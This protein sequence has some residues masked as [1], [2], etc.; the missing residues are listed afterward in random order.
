M[1]KRSPIKTVFANVKIKS[2]SGISI[3]DRAEPITSKTVRKYRPSVDYTRPATQLLQSLGFKVLHVGPMMINI[4]GPQALFE[5]VFKKRLTLKTEESK[6]KKLT[7]VVWE[8]EDSKVRGLIPASKT[9]LAPY[10]EGISLCQPVQWFQN[11]TP[12]RTPPAVNYYHLEVPSDVA[13]LMDADQVHNEGVKGAGIRVAIVDTGWYRHPYYDAQGYPIPWICLGPGAEDVATDDEGHGTGIT[14][15]L[16]AIAPESDVLIV[17]MN[18]YN[19]LASFS[20]AAD[21]L[22]D[23]ISCSWGWDCETVSDLDSDML[24]MEAA[25]SD[26]VANG[27]VVLFA[28]GNGQYC[29]PA[30]HPDV[31]AVGGVY[32]DQQGAMQASSYASGFESKIYWRRKVPDV[33]GLVGNDPGFP[34]LPPS[35]PGWPGGMYIMMP[36]QPG[37]EEDI[38]FSNNGATHPLDPATTHPPYGDETQPDDGWLVA[39]GTSSATPQVA[40]ICALMRQVR[41]EMGPLTIWRILKNTARDVRAGHANALTGGNAAG[42][43]EDLATGA[44]LADCKASV[45]GA[46]IWIYPP[47]KKVDVRVLD[48]RFL[49]GRI[50][51]LVRSMGGSPPVPWPVDPVGF[52]SMRALVSRFPLGRHYPVRRRADRRAAHP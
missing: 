5:H 51:E 14:S 52:P 39:S 25:V 15:N 3:F 48:P 28:A 8:V 17:K 9:P 44:G 18:R 20:A 40:G 30:Q 4:A 23:V 38:R 1:S 46:R 34:G 47:Y 49:D 31:I 27:I 32:V 2:A 24:L 13:R 41:P 26:A 50:M 33:C 12:S 43:G 45:Q 10:S 7:K 29:F 42:P 21:Q 16:L 6:D 35:I 22:P 36:T 19:A 11:A 37:S